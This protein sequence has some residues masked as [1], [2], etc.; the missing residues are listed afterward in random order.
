MLIAIAN[1][2][3]GNLLSKCNNPPLGEKWQ[4]SML[5]KKIVK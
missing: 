2:R 1:T 3:N 5:Y 4:D